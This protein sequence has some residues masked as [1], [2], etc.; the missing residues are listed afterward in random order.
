[1]M[2]CS[3]RTFARYSSFSTIFCAS[4]AKEGEKAGWQSIL[5]LMVSELLF[6]FVMSVVAW[7]CLRLLIPNEPRLRIAGTIC[8]THKTIAL[9][10]PLI[11]SIV[12]GQNFAN[13]AFYFLP[14][15]MWH[16]TQLVF[17][18]MFSAK[19]HRWI[20]SED[21]R[22]EGDSSSEYATGIGTE[23]PVGNL[24]LEQDI[25]DEASEEHPKTN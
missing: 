24:D 7:Y 8:S 3:Y 9:G 12:Q 13:E 20:A 15:L 6:Q 5:V 1:M 23:E 14:L 16:P 11:G 17:G 2:A 18:S 10:A 4:F 19:A 25:G 22:L 21:K